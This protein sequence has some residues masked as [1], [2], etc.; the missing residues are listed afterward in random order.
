MVVPPTEVV[1]AIPDED[2]DMKPVSR[3][4]NLK[5]GNDY[6]ISADDDDEPTSRRKKR[7]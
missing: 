5:F 6:D 3:F 1:V 7:K 4:S 2:A